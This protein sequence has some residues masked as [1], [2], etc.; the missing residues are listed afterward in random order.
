MRL[1]AVK[2]GRPRTYCRQSCRQRAYEQRAVAQRAGLPA[3]AVVVSRSELEHLQDRLFQI[4]CAVEDAEA[5]LAQV[6]RDLYDAAA[7]ATPY[8]TA[9]SEARHTAAKRAVEQAYA[10]WE[11]HA[12]KVGA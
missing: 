5:A 2:L 11:E 10:A 4:R 3:D 9:K 6:E 7:W 12:A 8:E 1:P